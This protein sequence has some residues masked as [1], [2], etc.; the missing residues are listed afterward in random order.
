MA[1]AP[2]RVAPDGPDDRAVGRRTGALFATHGRMVF[3]ICRAI[4]LAPD[5]A[6][7][8]TQ[9]TFLSAHEALAEA[10]EIP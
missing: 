2:P 5:E 4:L 8:A 10:V 1:V 3:A 6:E 9:S 7:D